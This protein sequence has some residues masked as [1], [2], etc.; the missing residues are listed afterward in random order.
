MEREGKGIGSGLLVAL[1]G[2]GN[3]AVVVHG[4]RQWGK[5]SALAG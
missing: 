4:V 1:G 3:W 5:Q 2:A